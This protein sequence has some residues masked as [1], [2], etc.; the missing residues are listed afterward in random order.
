LAGNLLADF[1]TTVVAICHTGQSHPRSSAN[2]PAQS[3]S[4]YSF[5]SLL[6]KRI[7]TNLQNI[8]KSDFTIGTVIALVPFPEG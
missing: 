3:R 6:D 2:W 1:H 8:L 4:R 7:G 5:N